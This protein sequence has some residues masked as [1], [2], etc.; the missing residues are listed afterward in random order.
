MVSS[1][2]VATFEHTQGYKFNRVY[3]SRKGFIQGVK[4]GMHCKFLH[5][6]LTPECKI[7]HGMSEFMEYCN[8]KV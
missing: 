6:V 2:I 5:A 7:I 1:K 8:A 4:K 3:S